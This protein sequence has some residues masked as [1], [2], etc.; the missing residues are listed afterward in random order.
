MSSISNAL[1]K[2]SASVIATAAQ[3]LQAAQ[4]DD[5]SLTTLIDGLMDFSTTRAKRITLLQPML[6]QPVGSSSDEASKAAQAQAEPLLPTQSVP[7][8]TGQAAAAAAAAVAAGQLVSRPSQR[9]VSPGNAGELRSLVATS[10]PVMPGS[11]Q[12]YAGQQ[13]CCTACGRAVCAAC[14]QTVRPGPLPQQGSGYA[15]TVSRPTQGHVSFSESV[16]GAGGSVLLASLGANSVR[17]GWQSMSRP[18]RRPREH[19]PGISTMSIAAARPNLAASSI[20]TENFG[21]GYGLWG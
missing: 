21:E 11:G 10:Q 2:Q 7:I 3:E 19:R 9:R 4:I 14:R 6:D 13:P 5:G 15:A 1:L 12:G 18:S 20:P 16:S 17:S 8:G